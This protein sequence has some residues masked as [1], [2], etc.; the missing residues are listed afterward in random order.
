MTNS[1]GFTIL[2]Q[3][4]FVNFFSPVEKSPNCYILSLG[5]LRKSLKNSILCTTNIK[6]YEVMVTDEFVQLKNISPLY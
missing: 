3:L 1:S 2:S 4:K 6:Q 5:N